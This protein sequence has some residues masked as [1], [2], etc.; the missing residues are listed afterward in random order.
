MKEKPIPQT[1]PAFMAKNFKEGYVWPC[2]KS[3]HLTP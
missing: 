3:N 1:P 2:V